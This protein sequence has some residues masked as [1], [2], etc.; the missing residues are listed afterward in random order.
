MWTT[1]HMKH[2]L[3]GAGAPARVAV[4]ISTAES[5]IAWVQISTPGC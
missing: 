2:C 1:A 5:R 3:C 4:S